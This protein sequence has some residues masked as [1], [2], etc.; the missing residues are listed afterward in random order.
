MGASIHS[1]LASLDGYVADS[2][3]G[4]AWARPD[5]EVF[6]WVTERFASVGTCLY[7]RRT[8]DTVVFWET[9][10]APTDGEADPIGGPGLGRGDGPGLAVH[11]LRYAARGS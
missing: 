8:Y 6:G 7:G 9:A 3:G 11:A 2:G 1:M 4:F 10:N 5:E